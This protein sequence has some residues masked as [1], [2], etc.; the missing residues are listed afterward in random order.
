MGTI[1]VQ[2]LALATMMTPQTLITL[3]QPKKQPLQHH[4]W[5][6]LMLKFSLASLATSRE[7]NLQLRPLP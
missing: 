7:Q 6:A 3:Y 2:I 5:S 4:C 1:P